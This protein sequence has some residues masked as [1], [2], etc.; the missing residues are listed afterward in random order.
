MHPLTDWTID[1][2]PLVL[3]VA[4]VVLYAGGMRRLARR[5]TPVHWSPARATSFFVGVASLL[6]A[7]QS[8]I[9]VYDTSLFSVHIVQHVLLG[10]VGPFFLALGAP[11]TLAL[12]ASHR[13]T[14]VNLLRA[15]NSKPVRV[16]THPLVAF[17]LFSGTL[18]ALYFSPLY[19]L[20]LRNGVVHGWI[21]L[22]FVVVGSLFFWVT[23]G[24]DPIANRVPYGLRLLMVLAT[25]PFHAFLGLAL[26]TGNHAIA[27]D[28]YATVARPLSVTPLDDQHAGAAVMWFVGDALGVVA[29]LV[30]ARQWYLYEERRGRRI[31]RRLDRERAERAVDPR[32]RSA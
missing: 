4:A 1:P 14:Q 7:T 10:M 30:V 27:E 15:I 31:D 5:P 26:L 17:G 3:C 18:F 11:I 22:H 16:L 6:V 2:V 19:E 23:I 32:P 25:V 21:H 12:Q 13:P 20:S 8:F 9:G 28:F 24:L 29:G